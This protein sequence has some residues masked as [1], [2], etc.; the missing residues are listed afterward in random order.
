S[1]SSATPT[2]AAASLTARG[3][4]RARRPWSTASAKKHRSASSAV[5]STVGEPAVGDRPRKQR[6]APVGPTGLC[7]QGF[8]PRGRPLVREAT[9]T[10]IAPKLSAAPA[11]INRRVGHRYTAAPQAN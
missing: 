2:A 10:A 9:Q 7:C 8:G 5:A 11:P 4:K 6:R 3:A 1:E